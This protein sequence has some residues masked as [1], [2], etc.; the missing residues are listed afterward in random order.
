MR[1]SHKHLLRRRFARRLQLESLEDRKMLDGAGWFGSVIGDTDGDLFAVDV[2]DNMALQYLG[3]AD[4]VMF[5]LAFSPD[6]TLYGVGGP[7]AGPSELYQID[8]N[9]DNPSAGITTTLVDTVE[10]GGSG[11]FVNGLEFRSD[12]VLFA[13]GY[14]SSGDG[15]VFSIDPATA[16]AQPEVLL[17]A[18]QSAGDLA[19]DVD[20]NLYITTFDG[21]LLR[22]DPALDDGE[23]VGWAGATDY[24]G[25]LYG[26]APR[27]YAFRSGGDVYHINTTDAAYTRVAQLAHS[28]LQG[29]NGAATVFRPPTDLG[30]L[31]FISLSSQQSTL[32]ELWYRVEATHDGYLTADLPG[33]S[34]ASG[35]EMTLY[36]QQANGS[37][38]ELASGQPRLDYQ[39]ATTGQQYFLRIEGADSPLSVRLANLV[40]PT[41]AGATV[42]GTGG[43]Q[44][45]EFDGTIQHDGVQA[46]H[47]CGFLINELDYE[48]VRPASPTPTFSVT[49]VGAGA[50]DTAL[51]T[52][53]AG[54]DTASMSPNT[55]EVTGAGYVVQVSSTPEISFEGGGGSDV[56]ALAGSAQTDDATL[57]SGTVELVGSG[58]GLLTI[59]VP[60][61]DVDGAGGADSATFAGSGGETVELWPDRGEFR[62]SGS[63]IRCRNFETTLALSGGGADLAIFHDSAGNDQLSCLVGYTKMTGPGFTQEAYDFKTVQA[64]SNVGGT[65]T[66]KLYDSSGSDEF[67]ATPVYARLH[68]DAFSF[69]IRN[70]EGVHAYATAGGTDVAKLY[71]SAGD[72]TLRATAEEAALFGAG[73]YNRAKF[74]EGVHAYATAGGADQAKLYDSP[75][76]DKF[77]STPVYG[78]LYGAGFYNRA[79]FFEDVRGYAEAGGNDE[80]KMF[81]SPGND[82]FVATPGYGALSGAGFYC[83]AVSFDGVHAYATSGGN[84]VA[85]LYDSPW[86]DIFHADPVQGALFSPGHYY[87]RAKHFDGV[88]A[89]ATNDGHDLA[90]LYDS[91]G[92]DV[93][94]GSPEEAALYRP[95]LFYN[96]GKYFEEVRAYAGAGA[97]DRDEAYLKDSTAADLLEAEGNWVRLS[98]AAVDYLYRLEDFNYVKATAN[99]PA[100]YTDIDWDS[101]T[102]ELDLEGPW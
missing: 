36:R 20:G 51:L 79:K 87:N 40:T 6:G 97:G 21:D 75:G 7:D 98:S 42:H 85:K 62:Q 83:E 45:F 74:F 84:D 15:M 1:P 94:R 53:S 10:M 37:L 78:A 16:E 95:G 23:V 76:N 31:G 47:R 49:F 67:I 35:V 9:L 48:L 54:T 60:T 11:I 34:A 24:Y 22:A 44:V 41:Q 72:D 80:A 3:R 93:L 27:M 100:D 55:A 77:V 70:F 89:Y 92:N 17:G 82:E 8:L 56:A 101:L 57:W 90:R 2:L 66:A 68:G 19:F 73:F 5:D 86:D 29:I 39:S 96:R 18:Y 28:S 81:D 50:D 4:K 64:D 26:P 52:G 33:L 71:D 59:D 14:D 91:D 88:H 65:D 63:I 43:A 46:V 38:Q 13:S 32:G 25:L 102:F 99:R 61:V 30:P 69:E 58:Y 12:G